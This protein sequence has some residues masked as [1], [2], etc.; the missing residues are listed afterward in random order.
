[1]NNTAP[2]CGLPYAPDA[3]VDADVVVGSGVAIGPAAVI[4]ASS[5]P[6]VPT[7]L[8]EGAVIG[9]N[10]TVCPGV[11]IGARA[12]VSP[13]AVVT[14]S[15]PPLAIVEGNPARICG[16]VET[17]LRP[18]NHAQ[19]DTGSA[20]THTGV[21]GVTVHRLKR[22]ED[23]RGA[24][25]VGEF[26]GD[27]P[28]PPRR[29]FLV[30]NVPSAETRGEHAHRCCEQFLIAVAGSLHVVVDDG[31]SR[32]EVVLDRPDVGLYLPAM[33]WGIQYR[34]SADAVLLVFASHAYDADDYVRN[35]SEF[36]ELAGSAAGTA[37]G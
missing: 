16:Y 3:H 7:V 10:A 21:G 2:P 11:T 35:Y 34:Y 9:A 5:H 26:P 17:D 8:R 36:I 29:Y 15:V 18:L 27:I 4:L 28:F 32:A 12:V 20:V 19:A 25:S 31:R 14:R 24:L 23:L 22:V 37:T 30:F 1:M 6:G 33:T 13:G